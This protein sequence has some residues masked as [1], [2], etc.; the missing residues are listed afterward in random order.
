M[1][2]ILLIKDSLFQLSQEM[3]KNYLLELDVDAY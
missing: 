2:K 1:E 3:E